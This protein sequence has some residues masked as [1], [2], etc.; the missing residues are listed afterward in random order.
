MKE[1][2]LN[3]N[4]VIWIE[5]VVTQRVTVK[6]GVFQ[7]TESFEQKKLFV[8]DKHIFPRKRIHRVRYK[9]KVTKK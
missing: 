9:D 6:D 4:D 1:L 7:T 5:G 2:S 8:N 3:P